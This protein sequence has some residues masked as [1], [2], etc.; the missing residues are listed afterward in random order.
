MR[1]FVFR[2]RFRRPTLVGRVRRRI[3]VFRVRRRGGRGLWR[4]RSVLDRLLGLLY[5]QPYQVWWGG[6]CPGRSGGGVCDVCCGVCNRGG[7]VPAF[8]MLLRMGSLRPCR[9]GIVS[10]SCSK[11]NWGCV[12]KA[13]PET[14]RIG[15]APHYQLRMVS[16]TDETFA[17]SVH[18][19]IKGSR[20]SRWPTRCANWAYKC[21]IIIYLPPKKRKGKAVQRKGIDHEYLTEVRLRTDVSNRDSDYVVRGDHLSRSLYD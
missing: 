4:R 19:E 18:V 1:N 13:S 8:G 11:V 10:S 3:V 15:I 20:L 14:I 21:I 17:H 6:I 7:C 9:G 5:P 2:D 16:Q 12:L